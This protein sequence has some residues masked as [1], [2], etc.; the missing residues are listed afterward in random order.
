MLKN[1]LVT[2]T[3]SHAVVEI[4]AK[5]CVSREGRRNASKNEMIFELYLKCSLQQ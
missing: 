5:F 3:A 4:G 2:I 1:D